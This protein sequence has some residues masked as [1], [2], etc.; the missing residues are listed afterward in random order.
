LNSS[1]CLLSMKSIRSTN[2]HDIQFRRRRQEFLI[3]MIIGDIYLNS[4]GFLAADIC[5]RYQFKASV[6]LNHFHMTL[7]N[8]PCSDNSKLDR[9]HSPKV[10]SH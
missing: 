5:Y 2:A 7:P 3:R 1:N 10:P 9:F 4:T 8:M 6:P